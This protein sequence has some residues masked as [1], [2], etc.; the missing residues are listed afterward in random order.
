[1]RNIKTKIYFF[2]KRTEKQLFLATDKRIMVTATPPKDANVKAVFID[3]R[4]KKITYPVYEMLNS[5][6]EIEGYEF[7]YVSRPRRGFSS[8]S[9]EFAIS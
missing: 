8:C 2:K 3:Q 5:W 1:V 6:L 4:G 9:I 7:F